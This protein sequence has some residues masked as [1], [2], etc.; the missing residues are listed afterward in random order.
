ME[1]TIGYVLSQIFIILSYVFL[2]ITY[3]LKD[4]KQI[5]LFNFASLGTTAI[6]FIFL[7]AYTG[8]MMV[9]VATIRNIIFLHDEKKYG[10]RDKNTKRDW[11]ILIILLLLTFLLTAFSYSGLLSLLSVCGTML[12]TYSV[13]QKNNLVYRILGIPVGILWIGYNLYIV[14]LF[15]IVL[16]TI[17]LVSSIG[18]TVIAI[19]NK[20]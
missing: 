7:S 17:L 18:G 5:L 6:S 10:K 1:L 14:S 13:W 12:Y 9:I 4:R 19:K 11:V 16:E 15:G 2:I 20:K 8:F 3:Y